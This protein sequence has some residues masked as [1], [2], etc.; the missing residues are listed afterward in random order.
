MDLNDNNSAN[1]MDAKASP[2]QVKRI[3]FD[4]PTGGQEKE[5]KLKE[6]DRKFG[7]MWN[8][9][10]EFSPAIPQV[11]EVAAQAAVGDPD[12]LGYIPAVDHVEAV[13]ARPAQ[14]VTMQIEG[15]DLVDGASFEALDE[16]LRDHPCTR[17]M[18]LKIASLAQT[19]VMEETGTFQEIDI[20]IEEGLQQN[21]DQA[22]IAYKVMDVLKE[23]C[24]RNTAAAREE[25]RQSMETTICS[26]MEDLPAHLIQYASRFTQLRFYA[27]E[28][29]REDGSA[30]E[31]EGKMKFLAAIQPGNDTCT[32]LR[33]EMQHIRELALDPIKG[34]DVLALTNHLR[35]REQQRAS[36]GITP[37]SKKTES[38]L[39]RVPKNQ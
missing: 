10:K 13:A 2:E 24:K 39:P 30:F 9:W 18:A 5:R 29:D 35:L 19:H 23:A 26:R 22:R 31:H 7:T 1:T 8:Q 12:D 15:R 34:R 38:A 11:D 28:A 36:L 3:D 16:S 21:G 14:T 27:T 6:L 20:I 37:L 25:L 17:T 4:S 32:E 33:L